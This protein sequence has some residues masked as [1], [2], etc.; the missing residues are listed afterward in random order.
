MRVGTL[1]NGGPAV[2]TRNPSRP[3]SFC[4]HNH[5]KDTSRISYLM[6]VRP[7]DCIGSAV[8]TYLILD[9]RS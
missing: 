1:V 7:H 2:V 5:D 3:W 4:Q 9:Y 6:S 8:V